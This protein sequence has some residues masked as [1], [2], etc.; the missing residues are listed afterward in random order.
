MSDALVQYSIQDTIALIQMDDGKVN[1]LSHAMLDAL[2]A[3]LDRAEKEAK[4]VILTGREGKF[5]AGFDLKVMAS[6]PQAARDLIKRGGGVF[7]RL[8]GFPMPLVV[9][10]SGH[11]IAG[12]ALMTLCGDARIGIDGPFKMG[13]NE[14]VVG[15]PLPI[16]AIELARDR[17]APQALSAATLGATI[18]EAKQSIKAGYLDQV[19]SPEELLP[20]A[21]AAA[22][23][24]AKY[25]STAYQQ[26]KQRLRGL[27]IDYVN[28]TIDEDLANFGL[29]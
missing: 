16:I 26:T 28:E 24:L 17:L 15:L 12:G 6:S 18:Y 23:A 22:T 8:Y 19:V 1:A 21:T 25:N 4:A 5:S 13:L 9:A 27:T 14:I 7:M 20:T 2:D 29:G 10:C 3:A 11:A